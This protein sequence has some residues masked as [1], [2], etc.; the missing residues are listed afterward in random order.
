MLYRNVKT[1]AV[2]DVRSELGGDWEPIASD[3][4]V[5]EEVTADAAPKKKTTRKK[6][7]EDA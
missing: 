6:V 7:S 3:K 4:A 5:T 2:V 1:G